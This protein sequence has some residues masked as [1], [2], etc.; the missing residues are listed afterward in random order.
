MGLISKKFLSPMGGSDGVNQICRWDERSQPR[1][2][3][4]WSSS[5]R[6]GVDPA[7]GFGSR[8]NKKS[9]AP[10]AALGIGGQREDFA[11]RTQFI[12]LES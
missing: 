3:T 6:T 8:Q 11:K 12:A 5:R 10:T 4:A 2:A 7:F 1:A 9:D